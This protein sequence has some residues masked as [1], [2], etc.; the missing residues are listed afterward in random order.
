MSAQYNITVNQNADFRR[1]F[2]IKENSV[3]LDITNYV[4]SGRLKANI[5][6]STYVDFTTAIENATSGT[7]SVN[8]TDTVT[9]A[10]SP[11]TWVYDIIMT[12]DAG[13]KTRLIQGNAFLKQGVTP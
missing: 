8:L 6:E 3:V 7:F 1:A 13:V 10:M 12:T 11:G 4:F 2:Q 5:N 9:G